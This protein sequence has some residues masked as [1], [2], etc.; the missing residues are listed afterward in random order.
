MDSLPKNWFSEVQQDLWPGQAMSLEI[1]SQIHDQQSEFQRVTLYETATYGKLLTIDGNI[2][3]TERDEFA[4]QEM[5]AHPALCAHPNPRKVLVIG[6]GDGGV[7]R[8]VVKHDC[9]EE[10]TLC[11]IDPVRLSSPL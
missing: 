4:Y 1:K 7:L 3:L 8:E 5:M 2:Q 6:G 9:V 11:E 10:V